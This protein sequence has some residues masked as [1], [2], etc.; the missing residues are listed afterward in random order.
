MLIVL[1]GAAAAMYIWAWWLVRSGRAPRWLRWV[2]AGVAVTTITC[3]GYTV[4]ALS[5]TFHTIGDA[6][7]ADKASQLAQGISSAMNVLAIGLAIAGAGT[8][9]CGYFTVRPRRKSPDDHHQPTQ[10]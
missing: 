2:G 8:I 5:R 7:P 6:D 10:G 9:A 1:G 3:A 4:V